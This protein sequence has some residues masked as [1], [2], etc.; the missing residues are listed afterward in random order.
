[1]S[2]GWPL[3][4]LLQKGCMVWSEGPATCMDGGGAGVWGGGEKGVSM[5]Q[6]SFPG[7]KIFG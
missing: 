3:C 6:N 1:M 7:P 5:P 2:L 4:P